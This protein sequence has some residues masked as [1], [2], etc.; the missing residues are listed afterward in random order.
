MAN[1]G[2]MKKVLAWLI[3]VTVKHKAMIESEM[4]LEVEKCNTQSILF[5][6]NCVKSMWF[7]EIEE[8]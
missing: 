2:S 7:I 8:Q 4:I 1:S 6:L 3:L 5:D